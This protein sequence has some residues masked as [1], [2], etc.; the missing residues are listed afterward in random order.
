[1]ELI[2]PVGVNGRDLG[3]FAEY[4]HQ[5]GVSKAYLSGG[6]VPG[7]REKGTM[8][9]ASL[10]DIKTELEGEG[11]ELGI[12]SGGVLEPRV[13]VGDPEE[14]QQFLNLCKTIEAMG[15]NS[16]DTMFLG[17]WILEAPEHGA[18]RVERWRD[19]VRF[20]SALV[21]HAEKHGVRIATHSGGGR[22]PHGGMLGDDEALKRLLREVPSKYNGVTHCLACSQRSGG[23]VYEFTRLLSDRIFLIHIQGMFWLKGQPIDHWR[24]VK[25][26]READY[27]GMLIAEHLPEIVGEVDREIG[28]ALNVGYHGA[29]L[30]AP[31]FQLGSR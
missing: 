15:Q 25:V 5:I 29:L 28:M 16:I 7:F 2:I 1:M 31:D 3:K 9:S 22:Y 30:S 21:E 23:D 13:V 11:I 26:L 24:V 18:E 6:F 8:P 4:C 12:V 10:S 19:V 27:R 17:A 20:Y 14:Q